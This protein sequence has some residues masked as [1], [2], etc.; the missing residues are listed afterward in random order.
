MH[1]GGRDRP[2]HGEQRA[3]EPPAHAGK[4]DQQHRQHHREGLHE[5]V[6]AACAARGRARLRARPAAARR[7]APSTRRRPSRSAAARSQGPRIPVR[8]Q[9]GFGGRIAEL[10]RQ[11]I[12]GR[13]QDRIL[14]ERVLASAE[15]SEQSPVGV[16]IDRERGEGAQKTKIDAVREP[17]SA[18][19][20]AEA[21][22]HDQRQ[23]PCLRQ[24]ASRGEPQHPVRRRRRRG[25]RGRP[26][27][28]R[29]AAVRLGRSQRLEQW[30]EATFCSGTRMWP[31]SSM[32]GTSSIEQYAGQHALLVLAPEER[33]LDLLTLVLVRVVLDGL[34]ASRFGLFKR[35]YPPSL[36]PN[37]VPVR[38]RCGPGNV[39]S[40]GDTSWRNPPP[41]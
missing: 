12:D 6:P 3:L 24:V 34:Q 1:E 41:G 36:P 35:P 10:R 33:D 19:D 7:G 15:H 2:E 37:V 40:G 17:P 30:S 39:A 31:F 13:S 27:P 4:V 26:R 11:C 32:W 22:R 21:G 16:C 9:V 25:R 20:G 29:A 18:H 14:R 5:D 38:S 28:G 23:Q 8:D